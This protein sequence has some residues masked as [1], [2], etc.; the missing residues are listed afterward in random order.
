MNVAEIKGLAEYLT[1]TYHANR[2]KEQ[3][4]DEKY[5]RDTFDIPWI[6]DKTWI[7]RTGKGSRMVDAPA[8]HIITNNPQYFRTPLNK[9]DSEPSSRV[10]TE[11]NRQIRILVGQNPQPF[12]QAVKYLLRRGSAWIYHPHNSNFK[13]DD[14]NSLPIL[15]N[16]LDPLTVFP[17]PGGRAH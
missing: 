17:L 1:K 3:E 9:G 8:E 15:F 12:K 14:P 4:Q 16:L 5:Y 11:I 13:N 6:Q 2:I 10:A 7:V